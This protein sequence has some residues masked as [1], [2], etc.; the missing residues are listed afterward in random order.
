MQNT[1]NAKKCFFFM[2]EYQSEI[3]FQLIDFFSGYQSSFL[4]FF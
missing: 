4:L 1:E 2:L 3:F